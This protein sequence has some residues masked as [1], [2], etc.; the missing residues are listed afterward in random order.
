MNRIVGKKGV[1]IEIRVLRNE[2]VE[3][4]L[5]YESERLT[6]VEPDENERQFKAWHASWRRESLQHYLPLGWSFGIFNGAKVSGYFLA[7]PQLFTRGL[8]QTLWV[9]RIVADQ[10]NTISE[11]VDIAYKLSREK[12][13]QRILFSVQDDTRDLAGAIQQLQPIHD[14]LFE[15]KTAKFN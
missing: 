10:S 12:H 3:P 7:Q 11:L 14:N 9:E 8:T 5:A 4:I 6:R 1:M 2:D 13:L 15:L